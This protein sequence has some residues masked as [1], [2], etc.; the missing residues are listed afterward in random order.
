MVICVGACAFSKH[1]IISRSRFKATVFQI[2]CPLTFNISHHQKSNNKLYLCK[3]VCFFWHLQ[4]NIKC[5]RYGLFRKTRLIYVSQ[6][7]LHSVARMLSN[8]RDAAIEKFNTNHDW[9]ALTLSNVMYTHDIERFKAKKT[10]AQFNQIHYLRFYCL[11]LKIHF[12][13]FFHF[14]GVVGCRSIRHQHA[15]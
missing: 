4:R 7:L 9:K 6:M 3:Y 5:R 12:I 8:Y 2:V 11:S 10:H 1:N 15:F 13:L 14:N